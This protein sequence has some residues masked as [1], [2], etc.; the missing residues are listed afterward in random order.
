[1]KYRSGICLLA[2][3]SLLGCAKDSKSK[4]ALEVRNKEVTVY[5]SSFSYNVTMSTK[6]E[7]EVP[8]VAVVEGKAYLGDSSFLGIPEIEFNVLGANFEV[9]SDL[10]LNASGSTYEGEF[11]VVLEDTGTYSTQTTMD[12]LYA[13]T[14]VPNIH[15]HQIKNL[16]GQNCNFI[17]YQDENELTY[18]DGKCRANIMYERLEGTEIMK[19]YRVSVSVV[20]SNTVSISVVPL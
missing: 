5:D 20:D 17:Y 18:P 4:Y 12:G 10:H 19:L 11:T 1:M 2:L 13:L 3:I 14:Q 8:F 9:V 6:E 7:K 15:I 16:K